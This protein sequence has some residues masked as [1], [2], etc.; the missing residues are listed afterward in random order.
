MLLKGTKI[1]P[2][3]IRNELMGTKIG[4]FQKARQQKLLE[5]L[6]TMIA[7]ARQR[8]LKTRSEVFL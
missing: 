2:V 3:K 1:C 8:K 4:Q 6:E 5:I 7:V